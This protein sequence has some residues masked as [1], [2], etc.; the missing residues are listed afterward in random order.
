[1][2]ITGSGTPLDGGGAAPPGSRSCIHPRPERRQSPT[3]PNPTPPHPTDSANAH[4]PR[5]LPTL[6]YATLPYPTLPYPTLPYPTPT[7]SHP[8]T[9]PPT[10]PTH[11]HT[12]PHAHYPHPT[13]SVKMMTE[14]TSLSATW[15]KHG[16]VGIWGW[17]AGR[18]GRVDGWA[19]APGVEGRAAHP[20]APPGAHPWSQEL[21]VAVVLQ[22]AVP[23]ED[24]EG[25][26]AGREVRKSRQAEGSKEKENER[27]DEGKINSAG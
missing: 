11:S 19:E 3:P 14:K 6:P 17:C 18:G 25:P 5:R 2:Q 20:G 12:H 24:L 16:W 15:G 1:M 8:P 9:R 13:H 4:S 10:T 21:W 23:E 22:G 26:P 27:K 7:H